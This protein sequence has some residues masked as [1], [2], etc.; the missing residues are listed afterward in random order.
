[1]PLS[2]Q[3]L[4]GVGDSA[5]QLLSGCL[6]HGLLEVYASLWTTWNL[7]CGMAT[8]PILGSRQSRNAKGMLLEVVLIKI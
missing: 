4:Q 3:I 7:Y 1:M 6:C 8:N 2:I 5:Q